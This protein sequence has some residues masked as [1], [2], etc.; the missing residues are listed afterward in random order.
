M[1]KYFVV[2][3][4]RF[5]SKRPRFSLE[6]FT[7]FFTFYDKKLSLTLNLSFLIEDQIFKPIPNLFNT[8]QTLGTFSLSS[9]AT[10]PKIDT[11]QITFK[12][13]PLRRGKTL[14]NKLRKKILLFFISISVFL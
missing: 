11:W 8:G 4:Y 7:A 3:H 1:A 5:I 2:N 9:T 10:I 6:H 13:I 14:F 12:V